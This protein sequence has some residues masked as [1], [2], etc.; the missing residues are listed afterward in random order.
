MIRFKKV[1]QRSKLIST[2]KKSRGEEEDN[3]DEDDEDDGGLRML[4]KIISMISFM[5]EWES[6]NNSS[7]VISMFLKLNLYS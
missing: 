5:N 6:G 2:M 7:A 1:G 3:N 4:N